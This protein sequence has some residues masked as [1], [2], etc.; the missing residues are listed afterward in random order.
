M[1]NDKPIMIKSLMAII[2]ITVICVL[3]MKDSLNDQFYTICVII[4]GALGGVEAY[5]LLRNR[6]KPQ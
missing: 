4:I 2:S 1:P 5:D 3:A 6:D